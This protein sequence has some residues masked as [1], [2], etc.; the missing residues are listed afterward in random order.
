MF[1]SAVV[2]R[3]SGWPPSSACLVSFDVKKGLAFDMAVSRVVSARYACPLPATTHTQAG[4]IRT[5]IISHA[6]PPVRYRTGGEG[7]PAT[8]NVS[9]Y[10]CGIITELLQGCAR[11]SLVVVVWSHLGT[12]NQDVF[13]A[14]R[15][16]G[17]PRSPF[18]GS[19]VSEYA[20][21]RQPARTKRTGLGD[22]HLLHPALP[23]GPGYLN[24][25]SAS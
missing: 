6:V 21:S 24:Q 25:N 7:R 5:A 22:G 14:L 17:F 12:M 23:S 1:F 20:S 16:S 11:P 2:L 19:L 4:R 3:C 13:H 9:R 18:S 8:G 10:L 15:P